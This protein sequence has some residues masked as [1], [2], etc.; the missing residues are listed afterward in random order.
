MKKEAETTYAAHVENLDLRFT[1]PVHFTRDLFAPENNVLAEACESCGE[2]GPHRI[3]FFVDSGVAEK[4]PDLK[5]RIEAWLAARPGLFTLAGPLAVVPGGERIKQDRKHLFDQIGRMADA[6]LCRHS[7]VAAVGGGSVLDVVGLAASLV[8]RG[9]RLIRLP[10]T[11]LGQSDA[12]VGV[13]NGMDDQGM[14]NFL[15]TFAPPFAVINDF[16]L[17]STL[18]DTDWLG[19]LSEAYK[20]AIIKDGEFFSWLC[21][22]AAHLRK[23]D[24]EAMEQAVHRT[25][26][27]HLTHIES[28]GDPF[29]F[30]NARPL[31]FGHWSAHRLEIM[32]GYAIGHGEAVSMGIAL[33]SVYAALKGLISDSQRDEIL[34]ALARTGLPLFCDLLQSRDPSGE[35]AVARGLADFR[36]HLGGELC[37]TLPRGLGD[38]IEVHEMDLALVEKAVSFL[39]ARS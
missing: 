13:K 19:G 22:K 31:D 16:T 12:G 26:V 35:L 38:K 14:K 24:M 33:D 23:R 28:S 11:V 20:V 18:E 36:E 32:S 3:L 29:E 5:D 1:Y 17:L 10:S 34:G 21:D 2:T 9:L 8:H 27:L 7:F 37:I 6:R 15:G 39:A 4:H 30:G 25:A